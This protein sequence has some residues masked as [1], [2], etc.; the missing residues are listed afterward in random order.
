MPAY[1]RD[2]S[3]DAPQLV[4]DDPQP[5]TRKRGSKRKLE[6]ST[7]DPSMYSPFSDPTSA[8]A[9][10]AIIPPGGHDAG[11]EAGLGVCLAN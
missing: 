6:P 2:L 11:G 9:A 5:R 4:T 3:E 7:D 8:M 10:S 1:R